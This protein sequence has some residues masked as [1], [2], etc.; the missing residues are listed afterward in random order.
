MQ[1]QVCPC[2]TKQGCCLPRFCYPQP[3]SLS[4]GFEQLLNH[5]GGAFGTG[6]PCL[7]VFLGAVIYLPCLS[8]WKCC[9]EVGAKCRHS[10]QLRAVEV[11]RSG[12]QLWTLRKSEGS[13][14]RNLVLR[15][16]S[17]HTTSLHYPLTNL[18]VWSPDQILPMMAES[19]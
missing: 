16:L 15:W 5:P 3:G 19:C 14:L 4:W 13:S 11:G 9:A 6:V 2:C 17:S 7:L 18:M 10:L 1:E 8:V 12:I